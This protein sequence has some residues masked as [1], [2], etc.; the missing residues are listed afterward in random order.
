MPG[1]AL[2]LGA[3]VGGIQTLIESGKAKRA[4]KDLQ[5][6][7]KQRKAFKTPSE[8][9]D[10][11][12]LTES[13]AAQGFSDQTMGYLTGQAE[14]GLAAGLGTAKLLGADPNQLGGI[15]NQYYGDIFKIGAESDLVKM[16]KFDS[17]TNALQLVAQNKEAEWQS[18][19]NLI[20][21]QAQAAASRLGKAEQGI[22]SGLNFAIQS[23]T[24]FAGANL[25]KPPVPPSVPPK[26]GASETVVIDSGG[27]AGGRT[28]S[29]I[30]AQRNPIY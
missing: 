25:Y 10:I 18:A 20:K 7:F 15:L 5:K 30:L 29:E 6:L 3:A 17:F 26:G 4:N 23:L 9:F 22:N 14:S 28:P 21:D 13:N 2:L 27:G 1:E 16:K 24:N 12:N 11:L 8:V 19:D